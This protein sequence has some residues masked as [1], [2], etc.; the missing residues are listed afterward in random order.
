MHKSPHFPHRWLGVVLILPQLLVTLVFFV[1]PAGQALWQSVLAQ[2]PFGLSTEFVGLANFATLFH[3]P[4]YLSTIHTTLWFS[5]MVTVLGMGGALLL[6]VMVNQVGRGKRWYQT[7]LIA[8]YAT[9]PSIVATLWLFLF[10]PAV[11]W[12]SYVLRQMGYEWNHAIN[13]EQAMLLV[14]LASAWKQVSYNFLF[15]YAGL[16]AIP[17][18][19]LEAAAMD[20]AGPIRSLRDLV[21]PLLS[22]TS[23]FLLEVNMVYAFFDTFPI[24]DTATH[25]GPGQSTQT[26]ILKVYTEGFKGLDLG[27]SA[28]QSVVLMLVVGVLTLLQ[29]RYIERKVQY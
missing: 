17:A 21:L 9:A 29:F 24:L 26:M 2:D 19:L 18:S 27:N 5:A 22:P 13:A 1:W 4:L 6:A 7:V 14:V 23:F 15:F 10:D 25:G 16:Q 8:P 20:G 3:D 28:A 11:G 12:I